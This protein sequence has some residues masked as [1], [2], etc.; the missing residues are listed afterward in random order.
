MEYS[1]SVSEPAADITRP[2]TRNAQTRRTVSKSVVENKVCQIFSSLF[3]QQMSWAMKKCLSKAKVFVLVIPVLYKGM[4]EDLM[5]DTS[6]I[7][8][9]I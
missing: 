5:Y 2:V 1:R 4:Q 7:A 6:T 3:R 8:R 9:K